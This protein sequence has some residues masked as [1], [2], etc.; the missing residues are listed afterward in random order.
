[1]LSMASDP[2]GSPMTEALA[3]RGGIYIWTALERE[4][5]AIGRALGAGVEV[6]VIGIRGGRMPEMSMIKQGGLLVLAGF[7]GGLDPALVVGDVVLDPPDGLSAIEGPWHIGRVVTQGNLMATAAGKARL[8]EQT[9]ALA[10]DMEADIVRRAA[11]TAGVRLVVVRAI[12]DAA[13]QAL[14][15]TVVGWIGPGGEVRAGALALGL[16]RRPWLVLELI[17][18]WRSSRIAGRRLAAA[19]RHIV[20]HAEEFEMK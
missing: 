11:M 13:D 7:G 18:L 2:N 20:E 8:H 4:A 19:V 15:A 14:S 10:V 9:G 16:V 17:R 6:N 12:T 3:S 1:M 5:R